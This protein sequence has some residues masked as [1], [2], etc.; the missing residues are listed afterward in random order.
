M[1]YGGMMFEAQEWCETIEC[2][3]NSPRTA[4]I[5]DFSASLD[6]IRD[7]KDDEIFKKLLTKTV[8]KTR[9]ELGI[10]DAF[11]YWN[12][13]IDFI[14]DSKF[15]DPIFMIKTLYHPLNEDKYI[16]STRFGHWI[17]INTVRRDHPK[18]EKILRI[19]AR[20]FEH[21]ITNKW[22][23]RNEY[24]FGFV[25]LTIIFRFAPED[26]IT[27]VVEIVNYKKSSL[28]IA[29]FEGLMTIYEFGVS[30]ATLTVIYEIMFRKKQHIKIVEQKQHFRKKQH[31]KTVEQKQ[32]TTKACYKNSTELKPRRAKTV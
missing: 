23:Q 30:F 13:K 27:Q 3:A 24:I 10:D 9:N 28:T 18:R 29:D 11:D 25:F 2:F 12:G 17:E 16:I 8:I 19:I 14:S 26:L 6:V 20:C 5:A 1:F 21:G 32:N 4:L 31:M 22:D 15:M 7:H